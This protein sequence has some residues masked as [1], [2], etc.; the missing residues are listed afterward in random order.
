[1]FSRLGKDWTL[2]HRG[3][4]TN[5]VRM[6][7][8]TA[9]PVQ[10]CMPST[11]ECLILDATDLSSAKRARTFVRD[12]FIAR[13]RPDLGD[14]AAQAIAETYANALPA[15]L[16]LE[17]TGE[18]VVIVAITDE[19]GSGYRVDTFDGSTEA[20]P[21]VAPRADEQDE[22]GRGLSVVDALTDGRGV[23]PM[24]NGKSVWFRLIPTPAAEPGRPGNVAQRIPNI[25][26]ERNAQ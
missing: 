21:Q 14:I 22:F 12:Y 17:A 7:I 20:P 19:E 9:L 11:T 16:W 18:W 23:E 24:P 10:S 13:E 8:A 5:R 3:T 1:M 26:G 25:N 4:W 2:I 6:D 15:P